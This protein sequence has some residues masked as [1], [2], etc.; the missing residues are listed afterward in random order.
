[1]TSRDQRTRGQHAD[2]GAFS[3][4]NVAHDRHAKIDEAALACTFPHLGVHINTYVPYVCAHSHI[5]VHTH[6]HSPARPR[7]CM[8]ACVYACMC[9][10]MHVYC[11]CTSMHAHRCGNAPRPPHTIPHA[12]AG[13]GLRTYHTRSCLPSKQRQQVVL[14]TSHARART[15]TDAGTGTRTRVHTDTCACMHTHTHTHLP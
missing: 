1:M 12:P 14:S 8:H 3:A 15:E 7:T 5:K 4:V 2:D 9:I 6:T 13:G 10:C 11:M